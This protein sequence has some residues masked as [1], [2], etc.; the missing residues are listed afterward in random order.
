MSNKPKQKL[1][2]FQN[3]IHHTRAMDNKLSNE[4]KKVMTK[5]DN[6][7]T[8][9]NFLAGHVTW[10]DRLRDGYDLMDEVMGAS[11]IPLAAKALAIAFALKAVWEGVQ[12]AYHQ[13][14]KEEFDEEC[15]N[16]HNHG[17]KAVN[18]LFIAGSMVVICW[19]SLFKSVI[20]LVTRP[21][22]TASQGWAKQ[23]SNRF[24]D[25]PNDASCI[26]VAFNY[27]NAKGLI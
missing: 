14:T 11:A 5:D 19:T 25:K 23:D 4:A 10:G 12:W 7:K 3:Y 2:F 15:S 26:D 22:L 20:S 13:A 16:E 8:L 21:I 24:Q 17:D 27:V 6:G 18:D 1:N 9:I